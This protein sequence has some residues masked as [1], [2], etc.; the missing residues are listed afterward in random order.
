MKYTYRL[1]CSVVYSTTLI[2]PPPPTPVNSRTLAFL[3]RTFQYIEPK[4]TS[5]FQLNTFFPLLNSVFSN[6]QII[7]TNFVFS[8]YEVQNERDSMKSDLTFRLK[9][10]DQGRLASQ[11]QNLPNPANFTSFGME[12]LVCSPDRSE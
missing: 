11:H 5:L 3:N 7:W 9:V 1:N 2:P 6:L 4:L 8:V 12:I 10:L